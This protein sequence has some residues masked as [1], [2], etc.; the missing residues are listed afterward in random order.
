MSAEVRPESPATVWLDGC[1][2]VTMDGDGAEYAS[3]YVVITG[4]LITAV[5]AGSPPPACWPA[6]RAAR[7]LPAAVPAQRAVASALLAVTPCGA[8]TRAAAWPRPG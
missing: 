6:R 1:A 2:V 7:S 4:N 5:G 3:G 8:S